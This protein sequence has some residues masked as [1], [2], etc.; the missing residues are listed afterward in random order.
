MNRFIAPIFFCGIFLVCAMGVMAFQKMNMD[1][2]ADGA[3][4]EAAPG[5]ES[6]MMAAVQMMFNDMTGRTTITPKFDISGMEPA[7]PRGWYPTQYKTVDGEAITQT[8]LSRGLMVKD[9]TNTLLTGFNNAARGRGNAIA[10]TYK[11]GEQ[12]IAFMMRVPDQLNTNTVHGGMMAMVAQQLRSASD[13]N[14]GHDGPFALHHGVP[15]EETRGYVS[16]PTTN[17]DIPVDFRVFKGNLAD[18]FVFTVLT[19]SSDAAVA[20]VLEGIPMGQLIG[21]L[22]E[23]E[24]HLLISVAFQ[25]RD[26]EPSTVVPG[27]SIA[28]RA[29]MMT[30]VRLDYSRND[31]NLLDA[32]IDRRVLVWADAFE[33]F[34]S[35]IGVSSDILALL[36][37][38]PALTT[39]NQIEYDARALLLTSRVWT[40]D[41]SRILSG[42][43]NRRLQDRGDAERFLDDNPILSEVVIDLIN[44]LPE[45]YTETVL[46]ASDTIARVMVI[47][48]GTTINQGES[49]ASVCVIENGV[50]RC[51]IGGGG[52]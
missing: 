42:M 47:R 43:E 2:T 21:M 22:P 11:R 40:G 32:I 46:P 23:P 44:M 5:V 51:I 34:G 49:S 50:R 48:R 6:G 29:Y 3:V 31:V 35:G 45:K 27:P 16:S 9:S 12:M 25:T 7:A 18:M 14:S 10:I 4:V 8:K 15:F 41:E 33:R 37:P 38:L 20:A 28:R 13:F 26:A 17:D 52:N 36:G 39:A 19:N 30:K 1:T 24:P